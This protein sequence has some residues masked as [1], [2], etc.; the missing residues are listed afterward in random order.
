[1]TYTPL[2]VYIHIPFCASKCSYCD[3]YSLPDARELCDR[4]QEALLSHLTESAPRFA[5]YA[6]DTVYFGG[7]TPSWYGADRLIKLLQCIKKFFRLRTDSEI[8]LEANP[9]SMTLPDLRKLRK[10]DFNRISIGVQSFNDDILALI[11]RRHD[12]AAAVRAVENARRAGFD[13]ISID[14]IYGLPEQ[15]RGIWA[16]TLAR[17][18]ALKVQHISCYGLKLEPGTPMAA[19]ADSLRLPDDD[20]QADMYLYAVDAL[21]RYGLRQYEISNFAARGM[22]SRHNLKYWQL[23]DYAG[24]GPSAHSFIGGMRYSYV[25]DVNTYIEG[26]TGAADIIDEQEETDRFGRLS[27]YVMLGL[28]TVRGICESEFYGIYRLSFTPLERQFEEYFKSGWAKKVSDR[29][30][31]TP[32]G[33][34]VSNRLIGQLLDILSDMRAAARAARKPR[35]ASQRY[36]DEDIQLH[37]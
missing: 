14:L 11:G 36:E 5:S 26:V 16:T 17:A 12:S 21:S 24:F 27:E 30:S 37:F 28:R 23:G 19:K 3:F 34:L 7:G 29:W 32:Q 10:A 31:F 1:M 18:G 9:D 22:Q 15:T 35:T 6:V 20:L 13:N 33:F 25:R 8:T 2:G 4:Y